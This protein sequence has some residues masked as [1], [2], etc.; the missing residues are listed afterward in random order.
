MNNSFKIGWNKTLSWLTLVAYMG[1]LCL[2]ILHIHPFTHH[3]ENTACHDEA[4]FLNPHHGCDEV[5]TACSL[6]QIL[7]SASHYVPVSNP[8]LFIR[9]ENVYAVTQ[10]L[11]IHCDSFSSKSVRAPPL[12][13]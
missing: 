2:S 11:E 9:Q 5:N 6:C 13:A 12:F 1:L 8:T 3:A 10:Q 7:N 4:S